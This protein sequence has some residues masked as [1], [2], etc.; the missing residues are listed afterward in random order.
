MFN[1]KMN[2]WF[3]ALAL[4]C[5]YSIF[6][7]A[8]GA[9]TLFLP[10]FYSSFFYYYLALAV[11][12]LWVPV[13]ALLISKWGTTPGK[14]L[15]GLF[16][17]TVEGLKLPYFAAL[18]WSLFLPGRKKTI[19]CQ[20]AVSWKRKLCGFLASSAFVLSAV[21]G[22]VL[23]LWSVGL[24][25]GISPEGW[26]QY[27]SDDA[28]F[29]ISFPKDPESASKELVIPDS[30]KV[31][32]Y[33]EITSDENEAVRYSVAH[34]ELPRKW[35]LAGNTTLL[36]GVLDQLIKHTEGAKLIEQEF[37]MYGSQRV[38]DFR[39]KQ[40]SDEVKGRLIIVSGTLYKLMIAYP[41]SKAEELRGDPFLDSFEI[42]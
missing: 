23:A 29:K 20:K 8:L 37:K 30:G 36:K 35:R 34:L 15:F 42:S 25:K 6:F 16:I 9:I 38:L 12:F 10:Y 13:E 40:D 28:K 1:F 26:V 41:P 14:A 3:R 5:D 24:E 4:F 7:L 17:R 21:Y 18:K 39:M 11:P 32:N 19:V 2:F 22:N 31:L 27:S 33:Q